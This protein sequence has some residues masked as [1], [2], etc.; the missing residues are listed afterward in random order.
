MATLWP[1]RLLPAVI[2]TT[3]L[4]GS[5]LAAASAPSPA[6]ADPTKPVAPSIT[7]GSNG[8]IAWTAISRDGTGGVSG[9][10]LYSSDGSS[11]F[12]PSGIAPRDPEWSPDGS[13][14]V[15]AGY[16]VGSSSG[17]GIWVVGQP[18]HVHTT[19]LRLT[20]SAYDSDPTWS[21]DGTRIAFARSQAGNGNGIYLVD[22]DGGT[23]RRIY[24][25]G[26]VEDLSWSP[27]GRKIAFAG[28]CCGYG[29]TQHIYVLDLD[30][31]PLVDLGAGL[32]PA[33]KPD[34]TRIAF[35]YVYS[36]TDHD[37]YQMNPDGSGVSGIQ[38]GTVSDSE[39]T[40]SP[41]GLQV[42]F[43]RSGGIYT[44]GVFSG[45][46]TQVSTYGAEVEST[47]WGSNQTVCQ[48]RPTTISGT[49]GADTLR[50]SSGVDVINGLGGD[51]III[52]MQGQDIICGGAGDDWVSYE[53]QTAPARAA[54]GETDPASG[55]SD[56]IAADVENL[57]GGAGPDY[58][59]GDDRSNSLDGGRGDDSIHGGGGDDLLVGWAGDDEVFGDDGS[60]ELTGDAGDDV[61]RGGDGDD[62]LIG[63]EDADLIVGGPGTMDLADY[64]GRTQPVTVTLG[65][66]AGE[67]GGKVDG[68]AD[69]RDTVK[70][71]VENVTGGNGAD[72]LIGNDL[73]N[74]IR[75]NG[76]ADTMRGG[77]GKDLIRAQD[78]AA[79]AVI[80]CG[81]DTDS[82]AIKDA[83]DPAPISCP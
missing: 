78:N 24:G 37:I 73:N 49:A 46:T 31:G 27:D 18:F 51:D 14:I 59:V 29:T 52:G 23:P 40:W 6:H 70:G 19:P 28:Y 66:P 15:Y 83:V 62:Q 7:S 25:D 64:T 63:G 38:T 8:D 72:T 48:G 12:P 26:Y 22:A 68:A 36:S 54:I 80:D 81:T 56:L 32:S 60:D 75:G 20:T 9:G 21:P 50:G 5:T 43:H 30:G 71:S 74:Q 77:A 67:D 45:V 55:M 58:L 82:P 33:W 11:Y 34:G 61:L 76:G 79:D 69:D 3:A 65:G 17:T 47:T 2:A 16:A 1:R 44:Y 35:E 57:A 13:Q 39:P 4:V 41:D 42:A 53:G 10:T